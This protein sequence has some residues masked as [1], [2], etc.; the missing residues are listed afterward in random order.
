MSDSSS[1]PPS[2]KRRLAAVMVADI[3]GF[4][5]LMDKDESGT[6]DRVRTLREQLISPRVVEH[7]G[8]VIKTTGD[9]FLAEF[10]SATSALRCG[11][12]IQRA[13]HAKE[14]SRPEG[15]RIRMRIGL[16][17][18][19]IIVDGD[20]IAGDGVI[21]A[22]RLEPL[23]PP[24]GICVSGTVREHVRQDLGIDYLDIG[25]QQVKNISRPIRAY[26]INLADTAASQ[27]NEYVPV[28]G[29]RLAGAHGPDRSLSV[30]VLPFANRT[31][32]PE[33]EYLAD[34][35]TES[36]TMDLS[37]IR[38]A[39]I[40][41]AS[42]AFAYKNKPVAAQVLGRELGVRF[43]LQGSVQ[44][45]G[46]KIRINAQLADAASNALLWSETFEGDQSDLFALQDQ[47]TARIANSIGREM[48]IIAGREAETRK[49]N[50]RVADLM[51]RAK[52]VTLNAAPSFKDFQQVEALC[53]QV[54][55]L[56]PDHAGAMALLAN[57]LTLQAND[58]VHCTDPATR[59]MKYIEGRDLATR[60]KELDP[61]SPGIYMALALF[62]AA[63]DDYAGYRRA[64]ETSFSLNT[65]DLRAYANMS[66][67]LLKGGEP[68]RAIEVLTD[69]INLDP[70]R[71]L[72]AV[73]ANM[74][75]A[76]FMRGD[77]DAA[78]EWA[79]R[80]S[81]MNPSSP[82][83]Y[84][85][86]AMAYQLKGDDARARVAAADLRRV[87]ATFLLSSF[88]P[89]PSSPAAYKQYFDERLAPAW[90]SAGLPE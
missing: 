2:E 71:P 51:L 73:I 13:N 39:F 12:E 19:D 22:A 83:S 14:A 61:G 81:E 84:A 29:A 69:A 32:D 47:V 36:L 57:S 18:G 3:A 7:G 9:G 65:K 75:W 59:E 63:H 76:H 37:R 87:G 11:V 90:R 55:A 49:S 15:E 70:R 78:I 16:N 54:L 67:V 44:R 1:S 80:L 38:D 8:R 82:Q 21:I 6:F 24:D 62:A 52:A 50:P 46:P 23:A 48:V 42:T 86:L 60:A 10:P 41:N 68:Q 43:V 89:D 53:R 72:A 45:M 56:E 33:Q 35:M 17:V 85:V 27:A 31:G 34:G 40:V 28:P 58:R 25:D 79:L 77:N 66:N 30:V 64:V 4:S 26:R 5:S 20:D 74:S 88:A